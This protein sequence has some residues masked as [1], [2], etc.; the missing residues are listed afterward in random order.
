MTQDYARYTEADQEVWQ[1][2]FRRQMQQLPGRAAA[3]FFEGLQQVGFTA[4][5]IPDYNETNQ[6]LGQLTGWAIE[7]VPGLI[8][9]RSFF[10]LLQNR[11]FC[12]STW[13]RKK[14]QLDYLEEPDMFHDAF[15][16]VPM[17]ANAEVCGFLEKL[18]G[19]ALRYVDTD[20]QAIEYIARLYWYTIE[21]GLIQEGGGL[22][23]Y[24]AGI[25]SSAG[26]SVYALE[27][28][29]PRRLPFDVP[30]LLDTPYIKENFQ[31]QYFVLDS[32][33]QLFDAFPEIESELQRRSALQV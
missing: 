2:L 27:S 28:P 9:N 18:A 12:A 6:R 23:I 32:Y 13:L 22:K 15:G 21:F 8:D 1:T 3:S 16:H 4:D 7:V 29:H 31:E 14:E 33:R 11:R 24:G 30:T 5:R 19:L 20:P 25:L 17:L 10:E 26:E